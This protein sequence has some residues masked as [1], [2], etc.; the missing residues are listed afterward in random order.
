MLRCGGV[1]MQGLMIT[2]GAPLYGSVAIHGAKNSVLPIL[3]AAV[4]CQSPC[5]L[6][7]CPQIEDV[8]T[9]LRILERLGCCVQRQGS[10]LFIDARG[11]R[12]CEV[13]P[14]LARKM[15]SSILFLGALAAR[16]GEAAVALPGGCPLGARPVDLHKMALEAMG[17]ET[18]LDSE[19]IT[20]R[21][22]K[23]RPARIMLPF[24]SVGAT[25]NAMLAATRCEGAV[26]IENAAREPEITDLAAFL[27]SAGAKI[28]GAGSASITIEGGTPLH[29]T[30]YTVLPDR[31]ETATY[32]CT[33]AACGGDVT[34]RRTEGRTLLP[35]L[36]ALRAS[37][38][39][40]DERPNTLRIRAEGRRTAPGRIV[41]R[42]YPGFPTDAQALMMAAVLRAGGETVFVEKI[43]EDR[44]RHTA[45]LRKMGAEI[46]VEGNTA[47]VCGVEALHG[48]ALHA[49]DL[50]GGAALV[51]AA[52][53][54]EGNSLVSGVKHIKRGYD[55]LEENLKNL[56]AAIKTVEIS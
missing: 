32:L 46:R 48:A 31:I 12:A 44:L 5:V 6:H 14:E 53:S 56:G 16:T 43:F 28:N 8:S 36:R 45:E 9:A 7:N 30:T 15:R 38:C 41:T 25:E 3:A 33:A 21:M 13:P 4:L 35:V 40:I 54:A 52:L 34:L 26:V 55:R 24:P 49:G 27:R 50:R 1:R 17:A 20:C 2:G 19:K 37:G 51:A 23:V 29:G 47:F 22:E 11:L 18:A 39:V 10:S 42:P